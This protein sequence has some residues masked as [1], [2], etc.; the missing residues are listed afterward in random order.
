MTRFFF[1]FCFH[2]SSGDRRQ[3]RQLIDNPAFTQMQRTTGSEPCTGRNRIT[4]SSDTTGYP[5]HQW[6][7]AE[8]THTRSR[9]LQLQASLSQQM[10]THAG[11]SIEFRWARI[12]ERRRPAGAG[13]P[14][15]PWSPKGLLTG[16]PQLTLYCGRGWL[17]WL[18]GMGRHAPIPLTLL[19]RVGG[20]TE[21][22]C[23]QR[24]KV[25]VVVGRLARKDSRI[26]LPARAG[27]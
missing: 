9:H 4:E 3:C 7:A 17:A 18:G 5:E 26:S 22:D 20:V 1:S 19:L 24:P 12:E 25:L 21:T 13:G 14:L 6:R 16:A 11:S 8:P 15:P 2:P 27:R 10:P 23:M